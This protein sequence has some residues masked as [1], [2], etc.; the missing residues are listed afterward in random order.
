MIHLFFAETLAM[1][2][3][4]LR[5]MKT[6]QLMKQVTLVIS[7]QFRWH[8][9]DQKRRMVSEHEILA[10]A[11]QAN[12]QMKLL[13]ITCSNK[14]KL[15]IVRLAYLVRQKSNYRQKLTLVK[16]MKVIQLIICI[17]L[18]LKVCSTNFSSIE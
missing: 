14:N 11:I 7:N 12:N 6:V 17:L 4:K 3:N 1:N 10:I 8:F 15:L 2:S 16:T 13:E 18:C 9:K 5:L